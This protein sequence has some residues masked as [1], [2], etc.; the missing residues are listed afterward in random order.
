M[1]LSQLFPDWQGADVTL[2]SI[3]IDSRRVTGG[4]LFLALPGLHSDGRD[5]IHAAAE[6]G[7]VAIAYEAADGFPPPALSIPCVPV[8]GLAGRLSTLA[9]IFHG[10]PSHKL[11]LIGVTGTNGKTSVTQMLAQALDA[12][13]KPCG[14]IGT[15]GSGMIGSLNDHGMT[16]PDALRVQEQ[17]AALRAQGAAWV[18]MEVSSHALD[19]DRVAA[20]DFNLGVFTNLSRDHLDYHGDMQRYGEAKARLFAMPLRT[21]VINADDAFGRKLSGGCSMQVID[22]SVGDTQAALHCSDVAFDSRGIHATVH[23]GSEQAR[24]DSALLGTFNLS[25]LLAVI[26]SLLALDVA[27]ERAVALVG[28]VVP[29]AGRMQRIGGEAAPLVVID[30]AHTPDALQKALDALRAHVHGRLTCV[31]GCGGDRDTGKRPLMAQIAEQGADQVVVTDDNP[32]T[33]P[34]ARIIEHIL[35]GFA[36][37][38]RAR[39]IPDRA[40]A[41]R[42]TI[43]AANAGDVIL[44][45]GKGHE[46]YQEINGVRHPFN[47]LEQAR[48]ALTTWEVSHA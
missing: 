8:A 38:Q 2:A 16:T 28:R 46:T 3:E 36:Q 15:L 9:D 22:Y 14:V 7:A 30:Y 10:S 4:G 40:A 11:G 20:V 44:L 29:P 37:P 1:R 31:F 45:A 27:L 12:L 17:L 47:D 39:V 23:F 32:R 34:S 26:G 21:A 6:A 24:L 43:T 35:Q 18:A 25:N 48:Q 42:D 5:F 33:E 41:I 13:G 19:Q